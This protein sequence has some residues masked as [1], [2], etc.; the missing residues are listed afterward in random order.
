MDRA[1]TGVQVR[2]AIA[3]RNAYWI[4]ED[5]D[6]AQRLNGDLVDEEAALAFLAV[7]PSRPEAT[8]VALRE[9]GPVDLSWPELLL[10]RGL[11]GSVVS[12]RG[13]WQLVEEWGAFRLVPQV[14]SFDLPH[15]L[16]L[17]EVATHEEQSRQRALDEQDARIAADVQVRARARA[18]T[19][20]LAPEEAA[21]ASARESIWRGLIAVQQCRRRISAALVDHLDASPDPCAPSVASLRAEI[22]RLDDALRDAPAWGTRLP[23]PP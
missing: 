11:A 4:N 17:L 16:E 21:F 15:A 13:A 5:F 22:E 3:R 23:P 14:A 9:Q 2:A 19:S 8:L 6:R 1:P 20:A 10:R 7:L 18:S 12:L